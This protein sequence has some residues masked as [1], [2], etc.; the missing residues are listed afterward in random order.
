MQHLNPITDADQHLSAIEVSA[1]V[2]AEHADYLRKEL[3]KAFRDGPESMV[4]TPGYVQRQPVT[5][6]W[7]VL[8]D[9]FATE[10]GDDILRDVTKL[11]GE[12]L[13][14]GDALAKSIVKRVC[15]GHAEY[16]AGDS[17]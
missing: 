8:Q 7:E 17:I 4:S 12:R 9:M 13:I 2:V 6:C 1:N 3:A 5:E 15:D 10:Q 11:I 16:H 14:E